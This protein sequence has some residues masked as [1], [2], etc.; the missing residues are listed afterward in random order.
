MKNLICALMPMTILSQGTKKEALWM[1]GKIGSALLHRLKSLIGYSVLLLILWVMFPNE[2]CTQE[3]WYTQENETSDWFIG[4]W[5]FNKN[6]GIVVGGWDSTCIWRTTDEGETWSRQKH[7]GTKISGRS[8]FSHVCFSDSLN[9]WVVGRD[10]TVQHTRDGGI[11]WTK[12]FVDTLFADGWAVFCVDTNKAWVGGYPPDLYRTTDGGET[13]NS[14]FTGLNSHPWDMFFLN[15]DTG[16][17]VWGWCITCGYPDPAPVNGS[18][19]YGTTNGGDSWTL[20]KQD[21]T[22]LGLYGIYFTDDNTGT[23]V[24]SNGS[25]LRTIDGGETWTPQTSGTEADLWDVFFISSDTGWAVGGDIMGITGGVILRTTDGGNTWIA[26]EYPNNNAI[27]GVFFT[28]ANTGTVVSGMGDI[29]HT[30][31]GGVPTWIKEH[32]MDKIPDHLSLSQNYPNPFSVTTNIKFEVP[33][34]AF[35]ALKIYD[36][37]GKLITT[38]VNEKM[39]PGSYEV[40]WNATNFQAGMYFCRLQ[41]GS[42]AESISM[43]V[44]K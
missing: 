16:Y 9:G 42:F 23:V 2:G 36:I 25:I 22:I 32:R 30:K 10:G 4:V 26:Q 21:T 33:E 6:T 31:T 13:W 39:R 37:D 7:I 43:E 12:Q 41:A 5:F 40:V 34:S 14:C 1:H 18:F 11:T 29:L 19:I 24:G 27:F 20:L 15:Q 28:D 8:V 3:G 17:V 38:L 44:I 35:V